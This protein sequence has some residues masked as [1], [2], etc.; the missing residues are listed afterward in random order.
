MPNPR[1]HPRCGVCANKLVKNG[2]TTAGRTRWR[3]KHCGAST[4]QSRI[5]I[6]RKAEFTDFLTW[7]TGTTRQGGTTESGRTFRHRVAWCWNVRPTITPTGETH[8]QIM[9]DGTYFNGWCVLI[10]HTGGHVIDWQWCDQE[11]TASWTALIERIPAPV[12]AIV[13]GNGPL[14]STIK[15]LWPNTRIQR[16]HFHIRQAAHKHLTRHPSLPANKELLGLYKTLSRVTTLEQAAT[17]SAE[18]ATWEAHWETFLKHRTRAQ[19]GITRPAYARTNQSW[20]YTHIRTRR[21]HKLLANL[22]RADQLFTWLKLAEDGYTIA[23]TTN[24]LEG[25]PNKAIKDFLRHHRGM[26]ID[27]ARR[28]VDWLL[29]RR[30]Q[31][32]EDPWMLVTPA[33]WRTKTTRTTVKPETGREET[34]LLYGTA[35]SPE[36]G[37]GIQHGWG[38]RRR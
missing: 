26:S 4:T 22:I 17:W 18:F 13:D 14:T 23:K 25:G 34:N 1:N 29:Y 15:R 31:A 9:L 30:T 27:H 8:D 11:K 19:S 37:N 16:C 3:C 38:G 2:K 35:F 32:P 21:A 6:T 28:G 24:A 7:L 5:D 33:H 36:D 10:A 12:T 20:W